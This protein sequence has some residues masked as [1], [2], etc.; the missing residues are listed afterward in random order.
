MSN[1]IGSNSSQPG[2]KVVENTKEQF[3][4]FDL[5][6]E[7]RVMLA[8]SQITE[9]LKIEFTQIVPIPQMPP[10]VM[11]VYNWR[12]NILWMV[13]L[14]HLVG[15]NS[16]YRIG[17]SDCSVVVLS[18]NKAMQ[19]VEDDIHLGLVV[20]R[21]EDLTECNLREIQP[22][23]DKIAAGGGNFANRYWSSPDGEIVSVLDGNAIARAM[24]SQAD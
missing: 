15:L 14:G 21:V 22:T 19:E 6:S 1:F 7:V 4:Q 20:Y 17:F 8:I 16:W 24:P 9:V 2:T 5:D 12:G 3:L 11:G 13:D 10:W 18:P 23:I